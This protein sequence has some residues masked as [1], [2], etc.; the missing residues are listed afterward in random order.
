MTMKGN[1][2]VPFWCHKCKRK[3]IDALPQVAIRCPKCG[4]WL[5]ANIERRKEG[6]KEWKVGAELS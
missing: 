5:R 4:S 2:L 3:V 1:Q 6:E